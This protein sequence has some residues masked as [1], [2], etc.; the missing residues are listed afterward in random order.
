M[1]L[2]A[3]KKELRAYETVRDE[4]YQF[5]DAGLKR[6]DTTGSFDFSNAPTLDAKTVYELFF[7]LDYQARKI[8]GIVFNEIVDKAG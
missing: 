2:E 6:D 8:R 3:I 7:K 5:F 1:D 4:F